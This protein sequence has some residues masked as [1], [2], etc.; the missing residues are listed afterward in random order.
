[1]PDGGELEVEFGMVEIGDERVSAHPWAR[2]GRYARLRVTDTGVGMDATVLAR[3]MDPFFSTKGRSGTGLGLAS[4]Y[5]IA[6][7]HG[8][9]V[10][11]ASEPGQGTVVDVYLP[12]A[13]GPPV[14]IEPRPATDEVA[15]GCG[16]RILV[17]EDEPMLRRIVTA[18]VSELGYD[19]IAAADGEEALAAMVEAV[20]PIVLVMTDLTMPRMGGIELYRAARARGLEAAFVF[21]SGHDEDASLTGLPDDP[22]VAFLSKPSTM[23]TLAATLGALLVREERES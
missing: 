13:E 14:G 15:R 3:A 20:E 12:E 18:L 10:E 11:I 8:G 6:Q 7:Q 17:A 1:M 16:E 22:R 5:G 4:V 23:A 9:G 2:P 21:T 19:V